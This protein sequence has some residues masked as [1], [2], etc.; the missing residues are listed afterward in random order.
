VIEQI[1]MISKQ[2]F[3]V[4][5]PKEVTN[6]INVLQNIIA[7]LRTVQLLAQSTWASILGPF[8]AAGVVGAL[9]YGA[10]TT[11]QAMGSTVYQA[12]AANPYGSWGQYFPWN[13]DTGK[14]TA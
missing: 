14:E 11:P 8:A 6:G 5:L 9:T 2:F 7:T 12:T 3:G 1:N 4:E 10:M 13:Q